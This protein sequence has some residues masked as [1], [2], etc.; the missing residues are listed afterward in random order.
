MGNVSVRVTNVSVSINIWAGL[1]NQL[2]DVLEACNRPGLEALVL[3]VSISSAPLCPVRPVPGSCPQRT[4]T[5]YKQ[6]MKID[7]IVYF[8]K[9]L[10]LQDFSREPVRV[11]VRGL[12]VSMLRTVKASFLRTE[13]AELMVCLFGICSVPK[14]S[15]SPNHSPLHFLDPGLFV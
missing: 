13:G 6:S 2:V 10:L 9:I 12:E 3:W 4:S 14:I 1:G 11:L 5:D 8:Q 15:N 7:Y